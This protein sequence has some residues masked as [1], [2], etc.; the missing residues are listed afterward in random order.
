MNLSSDIMIRLRLVSMRRCPSS[1]M[2]L[3]LYRWLIRNF[4]AEAVDR[5]TGSHSKCRP[6][7]TA[8]SDG[9]LF[10]PV[11]RNGNNGDLYVFVICT[12]LMVFKRALYVKIC[13]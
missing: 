4:E 1:K 10:V 3:F 12:I 11:E 13:F 8:K 6:E 7:F 2:T 5:G 9:R